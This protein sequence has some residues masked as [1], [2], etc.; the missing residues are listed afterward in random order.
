MPTWEE[1]LT[2]INNLACQNQPSPYD[3]VRYECL[4]SLSDYTGRNVIGYYSGWLTKPNMQN[5]DINDTDIQ[6]FM[7]A[8]NGLDYSKGLDLILHTPGG[9]PTASESIVFYLRNKF[10][11]IRVIVPQLAMSAGTMIA[12]SAN[13]IVMGLHSSL[14]PVDPQ[15]NG[16]PAYNIIKEFEQAKNDLSH[17]PQNIGYWRLILE[18]YPPSIV[19]IASDSIDLSN[20]LLKK[21]LSH[22]MF[23]DV[24]NSEKEKIIND[25]SSKLN[26]NDNSKN[27]GRH[28]DIKFCKEIGLK[29]I[30]LEDDDK[31]QDLVL[32]LHHAYTLSLSATPAIKIIENQNK[33]SY[34]THGS[35]K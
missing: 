7:S 17:S 30:A 20:E 22:Y 29:T 9:S 18:K 28:F 23:A 1:I 16:I 4:K 21:W 15:I 5:A 35:N 14:G 26:E 25:I 13:S 19:K 31:L 33:K 11:D 27:H 34:I 24:N 2:K 8:I 3:T 10:S 6:G 32:S 12:C